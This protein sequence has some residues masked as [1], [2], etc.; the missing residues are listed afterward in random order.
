[1]HPFQVMA[2]QTRRRIVDIL[3]SGEHTAGELASIIGSEFRI[4]RA[5]VSRHLRILRD[6]EFVDVRVD[7]NWRWYRLSS[8]GVDLLQA[9]IRDVRAKVKRALG[10]DAVHRQDYDPLAADRRTRRPVVKGPGRQSKARGRGRQ[11]TLPPLVDPA[12]GLFPTATAPTDEEIAEAR[13]LA[14]WE[15]EGPDGS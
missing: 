13:A 8:G 4:S 6:S 3:A 15:A 14:A 2:H 10:W 7:E 9:E 5:A 1:M 11:T 12:W